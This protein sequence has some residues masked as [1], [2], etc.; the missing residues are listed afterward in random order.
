MGNPGSALSQRLGVRPWGKVALIDPPHGFTLG[1]PEDATF[2]EAA[3]RNVDVIVWFVLGRSSLDKRLDQTLARLGPSGILWVVWPKK[4]SGV[5][6]DM[7]EDVVTEVA[8][9]KGRSV[10]QRVVP[11]DGVWNGMRL[12]ARLPGK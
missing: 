3:V 6:S 11:F 10:D 7:A 2:V 4:G 1:L 8:T 9:A 12:V 5:P